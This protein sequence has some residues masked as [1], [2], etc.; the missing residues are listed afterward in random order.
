M[1]TPHCFDYVVFAKNLDLLLLVITTAI[2]ATHGT[3]D[4][5]A[6]LAALWTTAENLKS[7]L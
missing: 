2:H 5:T 1:E 4:C 6:N 7:T 3:G